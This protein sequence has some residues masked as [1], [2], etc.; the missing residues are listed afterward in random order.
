MKV[1][2]FCGGYGLRMRAG[3]NDDIPSP[4]RWSG[5]AR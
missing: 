1:V 3:A 2:L 4:W 5:R